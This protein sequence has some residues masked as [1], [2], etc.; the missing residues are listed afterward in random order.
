MLVFRFQ[1]EQVSHSP[2]V[3]AF[4][5]ECPQKRIELTGY[6]SVKA[7]FMGM[8]VSAV[9]GGEVVVELPVGS[10]A[11]EPLE[12][13]EMGYPTLYLRSFVSEPWMEFGGKIGIQCPST[14]LST[15]LVFQTKPFYGGKPHT[16]TAEIKSANGSVSARLSGDWTNGGLELNWT[17]GQATEQLSDD[18]IRLEQLVRPLEM[19]GDFES[20]KLW[21]QVRL[22][23]VA[24]DLTTAGEHKKLV[25]SSS[26][27]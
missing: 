16:V 23:L 18:V 4:H 15:G 17:N 14:K 24:D 5:L 8:S 22:A 19:Q 6:L 25:S 11:E 13:Y 26:T 10:G 7:K 2:P 27:L 3:S 21:R 9:L 20:L 1:A 12:R